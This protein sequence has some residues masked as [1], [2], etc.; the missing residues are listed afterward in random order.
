MILTR[1]AED[2]ERDRKIFEDLSFEVVSLPLIRTEALSFE[3]PQE[4]FAYVIFQSAKAVRY[5]LS[6][7]KMPPSSRVVAVGEK[8]GKAL[9][10]MGY[11]ADILPER[12][13][14]EGIVEALP[15]GKGEAVLIPRAEGGRREAIEGL[16]KKGYRVFPLNVYRTEFV[17]YRPEKLE[18]V[19]RGGGFIL[20]ASPSA[21]ESL[22][23]N[24]QKER[25]LPLLRS[26]VVVAIG[27]TTK[28]ALERQG[29]EVDL[30]PPKPLME[31]VAGKIHSF[32]QENCKN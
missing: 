27:K 2:T 1:S 12:H 21:V 24:L 23:A 32:W 15:E 18:D 29:V 4:E 9:K 14:A 13:C 8:T 28:G 25:A 26:L 6:G 5:F 30:V 17:R 16:R 11:E 22:F 19:L 7:A 31:E 20:F 10:E 3:L